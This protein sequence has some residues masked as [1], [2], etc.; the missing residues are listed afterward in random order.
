L[1]INTGLSGHIKVF[2][3]EFN[4]KKLGSFAVICPCKLFEEGFAFG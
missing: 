4:I 2:K 1:I 3:F